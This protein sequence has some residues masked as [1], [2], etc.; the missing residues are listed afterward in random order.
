MNVDSSIWFNLTVVH[1][2]CARGGPKH[3]YLLPPQFHPHNKA[4]TGAGETEDQES[5]L[6]R[7]GA[8]CTRQ[9][10][11]LCLPP[12]R[13]GAPRACPETQVSS[14]AV[15]THI[16]NT[17]NPPQKTRIPGQYA[18][19]QPLCEHR[20]GLWYR[21]DWDGVCWPVG[22][23]VALA[24]LGRVRLIRDSHSSVGGGGTS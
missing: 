2:K 22:A 10:P 3:V 17:V 11:A 15:L 14:A 21:G 4:G 19:P 20:A 24:A 18:C 5:L 16:L 9:H 6:V 7:G 12:W 8:E 23:G 13:A 1:S